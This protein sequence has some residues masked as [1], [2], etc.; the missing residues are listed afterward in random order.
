MVT[1]F[2][3]VPNKKIKGWFWAEGL[4]HIIWF[5]EFIKHVGSEAIDP[6]CPALPILWSGSIHH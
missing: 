3:L 4:D 5:A 6:V 1:K 2:P